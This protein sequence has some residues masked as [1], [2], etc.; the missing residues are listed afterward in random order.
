LYLTKKSNTLRSASNPLFT[1]LYPYFYDERGQKHIPKT[2]LKYC[3]D[4][5]FLAILFM[6]D[7]SLCITK[8][9][10]HIKKRIYLSPIIALYLQNYP[11]EQLESLKEYI[12]S[13]FGFC[14]SIS[15]RNDGHGH[16]LRFT[17]TSDTYRFLK[18]LKPITSACP[19]M[20]YKTDW[21]W[22]FNLEKDNMENDFPQYD[23]IASSSERFKNYSDEEINNLIFHKKKGC[24]DKVIAEKLK[25]PY[26]SVVYKCRELRKSGH[27]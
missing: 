9:M 17:S 5:H 8:R 19:S 6:D 21:N 11:L 12:S 26:W 10:N 13:T 22:R 23:V 18:T 15:R 7:G 20:F 2:L 25:R 1:K 4:I 27:L 16:I 24:T 14:F 3:K